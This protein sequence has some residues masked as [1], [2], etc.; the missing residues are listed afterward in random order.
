MIKFSIEKSNFVKI[1]IM[2]ENE[3]TICAISTAAGTGAIA[4]IRLSGTDSFKIAEKIIVKKDSFSKLSPKKL[5]Y[6]EIVDS[7][8]KIID[9]VLIVKFIAPHSFTGENMVEIYCHGSEFIQNKIL[10]SLIYNSA[11]IAKRGEFS[12]RAFLNG[13]IDLSQAEAIAD[14]ISS[15]NATSHK[16][17]INQ[18]R[19]GF[20]NEL[21]F[22]RENL[23]KFLTLLELELDFSEEDVEFADRKELLNLAEIILKKLAQLSDS[24][25]LGN[26]LKKGIHVSIVGKT[27]VG[28]SSLLNLLLNEEK[29]I[30]S[31]IHGTTRDVIEDTKIIDGIKF[32]FIDTAGIRETKDVVETLGIEKTIQKIK[33][34]DIIIYL[35]DATENFENIQKN[36]TNFFNENDLESKKCVFAINKIDLVDNQ[37]LNNVRE[38]LNFNNKAELIFISAKEKQIE[39]LTDFLIKVSKT[40]QI[41][42]SEIIVTNIRHYESLLKSKNSIENVILGLEKNISGDFI[43]QDIRECLHYLG[44]ITGKITNDEIL[45]NI[46]KNFCIGK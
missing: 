9:E 10:E 41:N 44:E 18:M 36:I 6:S 30:V 29:A 16:I 15:S 1:L 8:N 38:K 42:E 25:K 45:G 24:F 27:N 31:E 33:E 17:A 13:K 26:V 46:F 2:F 4:I 32:R 21:S 37:R 22:L 3:S 35:I 14:L 43:S 11:T 39:N 7:E 12:Q 19:G 40:L 23:L 5:L 34:S 28:K 20:K